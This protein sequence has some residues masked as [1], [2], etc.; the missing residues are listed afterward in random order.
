MNKLGGAAMP[1]V[2]MVADALTGY[3]HADD[4]RRSRGVYPGDDTCREGPS[5]H[6]KWHEQAAQGLIDL[7]FLMDDASR[8]IAS[9]LPGASGTSLSRLGGI[10]GW[11]SFW[12]SRAPVDL[13]RE[14]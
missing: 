5:P 1:Y 7:M 4:V 10:D 14:L 12:G 13:D 8:V 9:K 2:N 6:A 11:L 3:K